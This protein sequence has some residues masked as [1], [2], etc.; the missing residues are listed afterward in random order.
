[1]EGWVSSALVPSIFH[2]IWHIPSDSCRRREPCCWSHPPWWSRMA[3]ETCM[4]RVHLHTERWRYAEIQVVVHNGQEWFIETSRVTGGGGRCRG[5]H[6]STNFSELPTGLKIPGEALYLLHS[7]VDTFARNT[8]VCEAYT[9]LMLPHFLLTS[10]IS[11]HCT[12]WT[13]LHYRHVLLM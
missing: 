4:P 1:M 9:F 12:S 3:Y 13:A 10:L 6:T 5:K 11:C 8:E 2:C 7:Y